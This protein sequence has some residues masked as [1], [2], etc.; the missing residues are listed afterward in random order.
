MTLMAV[1]S[2]DHR[3]HQPAGEVWIGV[4]IEGD[5]TPPRGE[6]MREVVVDLGIPL[7]DPEPHDPRSI[8]A[9][10]DPGMVSYLAS[11]HNEWEAAGYPTEHGQDNVIAYAFPHPDAIADVPRRWPESRAARAGVYCMDTTTAISQ[12]TYR[13]AVA[14]VDCSLTAADL[15]LGGHGMAYAAVRPPGHHAGTTFFGGSCYLNN[16][17][18]TAQYLGD[19]GAKVAILDIDAHHG[20]GTQQIFYS[21]SDVLYVSIHID[22]AA[23]WFPHFLGFAD[24]TGTGPGRGVNLNLPLAAEEGDGQLHAAL[25]RASGAITGHGADALVLSMGL[26]MATADENSPLNVTSG[27]FAVAGEIIGALGLPTVIVQ[28][29]GYD[30]ASLRADLTATLSRLS[31]FGTPS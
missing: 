7:V 2:P 23:G 12:G 24:E 11:A 19:R 16:A 17:A 21:R 28:E 5:E 30:L 14:A 25:E 31:D 15:V 29:G 20:N 26:D 4:P 8:H 3:L 13:A 1:W 18:I 9:V 6:V 22:P 27:G 10:H